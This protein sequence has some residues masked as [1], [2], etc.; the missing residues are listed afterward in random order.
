MKVILA[1]ANSRARLIWLTKE[2]EGFG[3]QN[4]FQDSSFLSL[5]MQYNR[6]LYKILKFSIQNE[7][8]VANVQSE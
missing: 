1:C 5:S 4:P 3:D 6:I 7:S 2:Y 8:N